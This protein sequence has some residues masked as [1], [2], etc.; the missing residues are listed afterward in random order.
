MHLF[1]FTKGNSYADALQVAEHQSQ[2]KLKTAGSI[3]F[4]Q[5]YKKLI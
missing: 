2:Q 3:I 4:I 1:G 5:D